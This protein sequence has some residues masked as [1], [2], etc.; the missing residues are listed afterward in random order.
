MDSLGP[1]T[2]TSGGPG[3]H[4]L[5]GTSGWHYKHWQGPFYPQ[6]LP[7]SGYLQEYAKYFRTV[8][9]NNSFYRLPEAETFR[10]WRNGTPE[11]FVF[12]V[13]ASRY[14]THMK[15]LKD[16]GKAL[17]E[18]FSRAGFLEE[19]LGPV[20]F[21]LPPGWPI[22][23]SRLETFLRLLPPG[24]RYAFE[25]RNET[26]SAKAVYD[27]LTSANAAFCIFELNGKTAPKKV[28]ADFVYIRLH[29]PDGAYAGSYDDHALSGWSSDFDR[30]LAEGRDVYCYFDN[31]QLGYA[32]WN[33]IRLL[34]IRGERD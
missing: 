4:C 34:E 9:I 20:L 28:T 14:I 24:R 15:K 22:D 11:G 18:F 10:N 31:D 23:L 32:A 19:K 17:E 16:P 13:K 21:Q 30:W 6:G 12:A 8:E 5:I 27:L 3:R 33:A 25:F 29:G 26:W 1:E 7:S 2:K